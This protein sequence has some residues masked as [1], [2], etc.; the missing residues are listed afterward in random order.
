MG[1]R[2][3]AVEAM[4][5]SPAFWRG[6]RVL[7]TG[8]TGFKG[9]W[10]A[11][12]LRRLGAQ[13]TGFA[14]APHTDPSLHRILG[15]P[16]GCIGD[17]AEPAAVRAAVA[18]ADPEVVI[19]M[20]AQALVRRSYAEPART[21]AV[22]ALGTA[23]LLDALRG[24]DCRIL[25]VTSDKV[26]ANDESGR[27]YAED[28][29]LGGS[30]P[31]SASKAAAEHVIAAYRQ[32]YGMRVAVAR[33]G[34]VIGGGDWAADRLVPDIWRA[35]RAGKPLRLRHPAATRPWQHALDCLHGYLLYAQDAAAAPA[36]NFA[37]AG[38]S[39]TVAQTAEHLLGGHGWE[40]D[41]QP[42]P[43]EHKVLRLDPA[44][45]ARTLGWR[46]KLSAEQALDWTADWYRAFDAGRDMRAECLRQI[47]AFEALR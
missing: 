10:A 21:F 25:A 22:N 35:G 9:A 5:L 2:P 33:A 40:R 44:L 46:C 13:V 17:I 6:K 19:H 27:A 3:G 29:T 42:G 15:A 43:P 28:A 12:W 45:A 32:S 8:H 4:E 37:P 41:P 14:L 20:A 16:D 38:E 1:R 47:A 36:L 31:Y 26:Y 23:H 7:L 34:N 18:A 11:L 24:R 30:D 39:A